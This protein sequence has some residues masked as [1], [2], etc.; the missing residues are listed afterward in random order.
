MLDVWPYLRHL[1]GLSPSVKFRFLL[2]PLYASLAAGVVLAEPAREII[3]TRSSSGQFLVQEVRNRPSPWAPAPVAS[4]VPIASGM[5]FLITAP[6][7]SPL[8]ESDPIPLEAETLGVSAERIK[9][10]FL[11]ALGLPD[12]WAG[13]I[14]L[15]INSALTNNH[16]PLLTG[17]YRPDGWSYDLELPKKIREEIFVRAVVRTLLQELCDRN[18]GRRS[19]EVPF[20]LV[21]GLSAHLRAYNIPTFVIRPNVQTPGAQDMRIKGLADVRAALRQ[22]A[23]LSFQ[24]LSW[25]ERSDVVGTDEPLYCNCAQL[26]FDSLLRFNDGQSCF[27]VFLDQLPRHLNWQVAFLQAFHTH[28]HRL[29]DVEKWWALNCVAFTESDLTENGTEKECLQR[30]QKVLDVP[31]QA[32]LAKSMLPTEIL[33]TLQEVILQW[34]ADKARPVLQRA[35]RGLEELQM[36]TYRYEMNLDASTPAAQRDVRA[37][38]AGQLGVAREVSPLVTR[39]LTT[40]INYQKQGAGDGSYSA[41]TLLRKETVK[42]LNELDRQREALRAKF[43]TAKRASE[44]SQTASGR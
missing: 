14:N 42:Q 37:R 24:Q 11:L 15:I 44:L 36:Y 3:T 7:V 25:P 34:D 39:Y 5:A 20:W 35:V 33:L 16:E 2:I 10:L 8:E 38:A 23:P 29:L 6:P 9:G 26:L 17:I 27:Q 40:L 4:R 30:L 28:F 13:K 41:R 21:E 43:M 18:A 1:E 19:V 12:E 22:R 32:R 31:V